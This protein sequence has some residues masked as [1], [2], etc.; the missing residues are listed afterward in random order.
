MKILLTD[1][2]TLVADNDISLEIFKKFGDTVLFDN[3]SHKELLVAAAD[4]DIILCNKTVIDR[5]IFAVAKKLR[6]IG[7]FATGYNNID[8]SA[9]KEYGVTVC[10]AAE[11]STNAVAQQVMGYILIHFTKIPQYNKFVKE[12][13]WKKSAIF[14]HIS[15]GADEVYDKV[16]GIVGYGSIGKAVAKA[17]LGLG[18][19]VKVYTRTPKIDD[20]V[21]FV[22]FDELLNTSDVITM[23]CPLNKDSEKMMNSETFSKMKKGAFFINT[24]RGG[25]I[26][27]NALFE[28]LK[29][30]QL[31][32]AAVDVLTTE[33]MNENCVL[34]NAP[35]IIITPHSAWSPLTTRK[36]LVKLV[37]ENLN[38]FLEGKPRSVVSN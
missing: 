37:A 36:R 11:Y 9:A 8:I 12:G 34:W 30:G 13:G 28:A 22:S 23:H 16:L 3:I 19:K 38:A 1:T 32:G 17:A 18:M 7:T 25:V 29:S 26:D 27:E 20:N 10:N 33:P 24:A 21:E 5:E 6:Y 2:A 35:N 4:A 14:S 31:S 15:F